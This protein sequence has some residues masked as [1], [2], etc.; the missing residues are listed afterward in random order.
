H[1]SYLFEFLKSVPATTKVRGELPS[2]A[3]FL[4]PSI[5]TEV[6]KRPFTWKGAQ[7][8]PGFGPVN[9]AAPG[10]AVTFV[11]APQYRLNAYPRLISPWRFLP[12]AR[13]ATPRSS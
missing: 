8:S 4:T 12:T 5:C 13:R 2:I 3:R 11:A 1:T 10:P 7:Y 9:P 6:S